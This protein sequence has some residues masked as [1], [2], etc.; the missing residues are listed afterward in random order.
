MKSSQDQNVKS[1]EIILHPSN[2][3]WILEKIAKRL[4]EE[5]VKSGLD[6]SISDKPSRKS[7]VGFWM[8]FGHKG[9]IDK[10]NQDFY[11][12][13]S[14]FVTHVDDAAKV[15]DVKDLLDAE[16][17]PV[18]MSKSHSETVA[19]LVKSENR[20][21]HTRFGSDFA[22]Q[23]PNFK[24]GWYSKRFP[25]GRKNEAKCNRVQHN[26]LFLFRTDAFAN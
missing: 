1:I 9:L 6:V 26:I 15:R 12:L 14:A 24:I 8:Y 20:L 2:A 11:D 7:D 22:W 25:D 16:I 3:G 17:A 4:Q 5:W 23:R 18:F 13:R 19:K 10:K 21:F